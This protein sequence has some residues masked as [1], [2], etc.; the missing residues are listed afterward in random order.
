MEG[1]DRVERARAVVRSAERASGRALGDG[2]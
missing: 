2:E 1:D